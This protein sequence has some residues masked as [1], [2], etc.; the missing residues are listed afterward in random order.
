LSRRLTLV[1]SALL[2]LILAGCRPPSDRESRTDDVI[3]SWVSAADPKPWNSSK[4]IHPVAVYADRSGSMRGFLDPAYPTRTDYRSVIDGLQVRLA[5]Q[6]VYGFGTGV[7]REPRPGLAVMGDRD[8]YGDRNTETEQ[9]LDTIAA[10]TQH[11]RTH[12]LITDGRRGDPNRA[13]GQFERMRQLARDWIA[14]GGTFLVGVSSAP[15]TPVPDDPSGCHAAERQARLSRADTAGHT[16][17]DGGL[18]CPLYVF[19]FAPPGDG[20][21]IG[22]ALAQLFDHV[23]MSPAPTAPGHMFALAADPDAGGSTTFDRQ[24]LVAGDSAPVAAAEAPERATRPLHVHLVQ[25]E[26][27]SP[28]AGLVAAVLASGTRAELSAR[29]ITGDS[30]A[31]PWSRLDGS[32]GEVRLAADGRGLEVFSPGGDAC[33]SVREGDPCGTLY[34]LE[35]Y[36]TGAPGWLPQLEARDAADVERTFGLGRLFEGFRASPATTPLAR[37]Y[38][39]VR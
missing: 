14:A 36:P 12:L 24:R 34:R 32:T 2:P 21:R 25:T 31:A 22:S 35:L 6:V 11:G 29:G 8:W 30:A 18:R 9:A 13:Y 39:L 10:D 20:V 3:R 15:F 33:R 37:A 19:A 5:P 1:A 17:A 28:A 4:P 38:L 7:R 27:A 26:T 23:W 16:A